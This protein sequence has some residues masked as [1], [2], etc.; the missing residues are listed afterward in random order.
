V[1]SSD[2]Q[3]GGEGA[4]IGYRLGDCG[5]SQEPARLMIVSLYDGQVFRR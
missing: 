3:L 1:E 4:L 5:Q 2:Q